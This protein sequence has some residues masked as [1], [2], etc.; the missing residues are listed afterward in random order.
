MDFSKLFP[1]KPD[2]GL[3]LANLSNTQRF[4]M[5]AIFPAVQEMRDLGIGPLNLTPLPP[6]VDESGG[7]TSHEL[8]TRFT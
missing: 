5:V 7:D 4:I 3:L 6:H 8:S 2:D 1:G